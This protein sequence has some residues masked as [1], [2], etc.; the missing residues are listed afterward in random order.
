MRVPK[1]KTSESARTL[2]K[3]EPHY[4]RNEDILDKDKNKSTIKKS[5]PSKKELKATKK[6]SVEVLDIDDQQDSDERVFS[7]TQDK[8]ETI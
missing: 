2:L 3:K 6:H 4:L 8:D 7:V 5:E 1:L